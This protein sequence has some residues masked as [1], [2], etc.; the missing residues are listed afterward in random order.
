MCKTSD[1]YNSTTSF[2]L[3]KACCPFVYVGCDPRLISS[4]HSGQVLALDTAPRESSS[5]ITTS[6][7]AKTGYKSY[8]DIKD[9][10]VTYY[11]DA[12]M[13]NPFIQELFS[14]RCGNEMVVAKDNYY[15]PMGVYKPHYTIVGKVGK[16]I[17]IP[18][19]LQDS[20]FQRQDLLGRQ[21]WRRN[22]NN[23]EVNLSTSGIL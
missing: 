23:F 20:Q 2:G 4:R 15:D 1:S 5:L 8:A 7:G 3:D 16:D 11:Y 19:W 9:G 17:K 10:D 13:A 22:Q 21:M 14:M 18:L 6:S 12:S